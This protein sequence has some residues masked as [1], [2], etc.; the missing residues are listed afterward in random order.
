MELGSPATTDTPPAGS[1]EMPGPEVL[2]P[3]ADRYGIEVI[4][5][6]RRISHPEGA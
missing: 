5:P 1:L 6:P 4:G 3:V 2:A